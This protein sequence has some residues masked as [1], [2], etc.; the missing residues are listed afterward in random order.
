MTGTRL[1]RRTLALGATSASLASLFGVHRAVS[2]TPYAPDPMQAAE[3]LS[4][5]EVTEH[6]PALYT[7]YDRMHPDAQAI[8]PR[9]VV[10]GWF[11]EDFQSRGPEPAVATGVTYRDWTWAVNRK[12]YRD[13]AE[14]SFAQAFADGSTVEDVVRLVLHE[15]EWRWFFGR[16]LEWVDEQIQRFTQ[17]RNVA[18]SGE[19]PFDLSTVTL[20]D[21]MLD[22]LP[23]TLE[24]EHTMAVQAS[25][26]A[27]SPVIPDWADA[28][29]VRQYV[30]DDEPYPLGYAQV[31][32]LKQEHTPAEAIR[33]AVEEYETTPPF[34]LQAWNLEPDSGTPYARFETF[35]SDAVGMARNVMWGDADGE[36]VAIISCIDERGLEAMANALAVIAP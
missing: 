8:I 31:Y 4:R 33:L 20:A 21:D 6:I 17:T 28:T 26:A 35:G 16:D 19:A 27:V 15:G 2:Q 23:D 13:V 9:H 24:L 25:L 22:R 1:S 29:D 34:T 14:V 32:R 30:V 5:L 3:E 10:I 7:F 18:F 12:T 36:H 11:R